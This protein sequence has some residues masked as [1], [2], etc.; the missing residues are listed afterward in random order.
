LHDLIQNHEKILYCDSDVIFEHD[1]SD[2]FNIDINKKYAAV[3]KDAVGMC[4]HYDHARINKEYYFNSGVMLIN[5]N[6][7]RN[8][9]AF[10]KMINLR[11]SL[12]NKYMDQDVFNIYFGD[13][14]MYLD[15]RY[16]YMISNIKLDGKIINHIFGTEFTRDQY[17]IIHYTGITGENIKST[18]LYAAW[19][20]YHLLSPYADINISPVKLPPKTPQ[21]SPHRANTLTLL[22][23]PFYQLGKNFFI[24]NCTRIINGG[25]K[26]IK[27]HVDKAQSDQNSQF[28]KKLNYM[29]K[30]IFQFLVF[31][32]APVRE[33]SILFIEAALCHGETMPGFAHY[34]EQLGFSV[35]VL[36]TL[37]IFDFEP[38]SRM[39][40][41]T[42][43]LYQADRYSMPVM[44]QLAK[45]RQYEYIVFNSR[46]LY[47]QH[48]DTNYPLFYE[49]F[50]HIV[51]PKRK[52]ISIEHHLEHIQC[53]MRDI[54]V[55]ENIP[56]KNS[57][58][59]NVVYPFYFG[60]IQI[61]EKNKDNIRFIAVGNFE[62]KRRD[63]E[64]LY[65]GMRDLIA[66]EYTHFEVI[67]IG[68]GGNKIEIPRDLKDKI[69]IYYDT[70]Y[71]K[72]FS[73]MEES[74]YFLPLF[75]PLNKE[76]LRY[77]TFGTSGSI[78]LIYTFAKP[79]II[80]EKFASRF[81]FNKDNSIVYTDNSNFS[82]AM[83]Q[84]MEMS[85]EK[86]QAMQTE[87]IKVCDEKQKDSLSTLHNIFD[88]HGEEFFES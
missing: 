49:H 63:H 48:K 34:F 6:R 46:T 72:I 42:I 58:H 13:D 55:L 56:N 22:I 88:L 17:K 43:H 67:L 75:N 5:A 80:H 77:L 7:L 45:I 41:T 84:A 69:S 40:T 19:E 31:Q 79:C 14:V 44:L 38:F 57:L 39:D 8:E 59:R 36:M 33:N 11:S 15:Y 78:Q 24:N 64:L 30:E 83:R 71:E 54:I 9:N 27:N 61:T 73:S 82:L 4:L 70:T 16:N 2:I 1:I 62:S 52:I 87:L 25:T 81:Y 53:D 12:D 68:R 3:V 21:Q 50:R 32:N 66:S 74:D 29:R 10:Y 86:Y 35:D 26:K 20:K 85:S 65:I 23:R 76:H 60:N 51:H 47:Y 18:N 28:D 37:K